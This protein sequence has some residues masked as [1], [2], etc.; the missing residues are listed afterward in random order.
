MAS[1]QVPPL[2]TPRS[3]APWRQAGS[4]IVE[5]TPARTLERIRTSHFGT[6]PAVRVRAL[7]ALGPAGTSQRLSLVEATAAT[8]DHFLNMPPLPKVRMEDAAACRGGQAMNGVGLRAEALVS[9]LHDD[10]DAAV[11][12][13]AAKTLGLLAPTLGDHAELGTRALARSLAEDQEPLVREAAFTTITKLG[14]VAGAVGVEALT[15]D[16]W[17]NTSPELRCRTAVALG[18]LGPAAGHEGAQALVAALV[19]EVEPSVR[20]AAARA[21]GRLRRAAGTDG[22]HMLTLAL[23]NDEDVHVRREAADALAFLGPEW[24]GPDVVPALV[25]ALTTDGNQDVQLAASTAL[26]GHGASA[27]PHLLPCLDW[28]QHP[29]VRLA[30]LNSLRAVADSTESDS[31]VHHHEALLHCIAQ[32]HHEPGVHSAMMDI[33]AALGDRAGPAI[34]GLLRLAQRPL[35]TESEDAQRVASKGASAL[36]TNIL[37][38]LFEDHKH[39]FESAVGAKAVAFLALRGRQGLELMADRGEPAPGQRSRTAREVRKA[40]G[41]LKRGPLVQHRRTLSLLPGP[42]ISGHVSRKI[43]LEP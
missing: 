26:E 23:R 1:I 9:A 25:A 10:N 34:R 42:A 30:A 13:T 12:A 3:P 17:R 20:C 36:A 38:A 19:S 2:L 22:V 43:V 18:D 31:V 29:R 28:G 15:Q 33:F 40:V 37:V 39:I 11:R 16:L 21:L 14:P 6:T 32:H 8:V 7:E 5:P 24:T 41:L 35:D 4:S 27:I